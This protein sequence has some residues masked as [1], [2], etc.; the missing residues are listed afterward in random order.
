MSDESGVGWR[1]EVKG[2]GGGMRVTFGRPFFSFSFF[3][4]CFD[5]VEVFFS[6]FKGLCIAWG[7]H[8]GGV[9]FLF[10]SRLL[11]GNSYHRTKISTKY[12]TDCKYCG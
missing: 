10:T 6:W 11:D 5:T 3:F 8:L 4:F 9:Y 7:W 1:C 2:R 12:E